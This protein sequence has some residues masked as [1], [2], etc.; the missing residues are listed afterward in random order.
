MANL[1]AEILDS[2]EYFTEISRHEQLVKRTEEYIKWVEEPFPHGVC[3]ETKTFNVVLWSNTPKERSYTIK[4]SKGLKWP[5]PQ[6]NRKFRT[7]SNFDV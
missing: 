7:S 6:L 3:Y 4:L 2:V 1:W 5:T